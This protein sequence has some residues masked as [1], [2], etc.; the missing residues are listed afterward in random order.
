MSRE[1]WESY[2]GEGGALAETHDFRDEKIAAQ[3]LTAS[4]MVENA[5]IRSAKSPPT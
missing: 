4:H 2:A 1:F 3:L 5:T